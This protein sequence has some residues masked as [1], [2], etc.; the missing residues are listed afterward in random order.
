MTRMLPTLP[1]PLLPRWIVSV[2]T[3]MAA[4]VVLP[5][6]AP[7]TVSLALEPTIGEAP[8]LFSSG[9]V[10][11]RDADVPVWGIA[12]PGETVGVAIGGQTK[13]ATADGNGHW[14]VVLDP[15]P[16][17]GPHE[18]T[19]TGSN[20]IVLSDI[21]IGDVWVC[22]G[23]SNMVI[24]RARA[25]DMA[26]TP[27]VRTIG[28]RGEWLDRP[29]AMAFAFA[30]ELAFALD[31]PIGII[32]RAAGGT[33][34]RS[35]LPA[36]AALD[37][38][39]E[40]QA[41]LAGW[42]GFGESYQRHIAPFEGYAIKGFVYWQGEQDLKLSRQDAGNVDHYYYLL[43]ALI[44]SWRGKWQRGDIP[45]VLMQLPTGGGI[46]EG[47]LPDPL[48]VEPPAPTIGVKM[49]QS[50]FN[51][52]SQ[53]ATALTVSIDIEGGTHPKDRALYGLRL[54]NAA[55]GTA[56][57]YAFAY[58]GPIYSSMTVEPGG[59]VRLRF[60]PNTAEGLYAA[61]GGAPAGFA[62]SGD[63]EHFVWANAEIQN[64]NEVVVWNDAV[65]A[66]A[67]VRYAWDRRPT[68]ANL[69]NGGNLGAAPFSTTETPA[70]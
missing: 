32:N 18:M 29:A 11:Q 61:G 43:P 55:L 36:S 64:G 26:A 22:A 24:R 56:Y 41:I 47:E 14:R 40:V 68:W 51:G 52:L 30:R 5:S 33:P 2:L 57:G 10:L 48:P 59:R 12:D 70:P 13:T 53:P 65:P 8:A 60:K 27:L 44:R 54:A 23:Q 7:A 35:W 49:R 69:F 42:D 15:M 19:V 63:G 9:M 28:L 17:G 45:F 50:T 39:P 1:I 67:V 62:I 6:P 4:A 20:T 46:L 38:D 25:D 31:V 58:S 21:L 66:P 16:A 34:I 37:P 3:A